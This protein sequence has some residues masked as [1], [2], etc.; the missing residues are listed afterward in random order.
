VRRGEAE[1]RMNGSGDDT[2]RDERINQRKTTA[3]ALP[4]FPSFTPS[5][6]WLPINLHLPLQFQVAGGGLRWRVAGI[7]NSSLCLSYPPTANRKH[8]R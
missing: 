3:T 4:R 7:F 2:P 5:R 1:A 6:L 8:P